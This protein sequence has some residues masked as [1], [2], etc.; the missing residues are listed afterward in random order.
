M[1]EEKDPHVLGTKPPE[2]GFKGEQDPKYSHWMDKE[3]KG[4]EKMDRTEHSADMRAHKDDRQGMQG[5]KNPYFE[6]E[7][8]E[9]G[10]A[11][12]KAR[13]AAKPHEADEFDVNMFDRGD[14]RVP[15]GREEGEY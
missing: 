3:L 9:R 2:G 1:T 11:S 4:M 7:E 10:D 15:E 12:A 8:R 5:T 6:I 14:D 13:A